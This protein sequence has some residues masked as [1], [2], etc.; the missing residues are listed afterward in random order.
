[1]DG[2]TA[3]T[4]YP[5]LHVLRYFII[6]IIAAYIISE[7]MTAMQS[8]VLIHAMVT[9]IYSEIVSLGTHY[10][11]HPPVHPQPSSH[12]SLIKEIQ[13]KFTHA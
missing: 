6:I 3:M 5:Y 12:T 7:S 11:L 9:V 13:Q 2:S 8:L 4:C 10:S 1:M